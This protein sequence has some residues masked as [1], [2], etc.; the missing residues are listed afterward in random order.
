MLYADEQTLLDRALLEHF[1]D[2]QPRDDMHHLHI[3]D[4]VQCPKAIWYRRN[5]QPDQPISP[6][7]R[8]TMIRGLAIER[9]IREAI[10]K[11]RAAAGFAVHHATSDLGELVGSLELDFD[12][13]LSALLAHGTPWPDA[14]RGA[15]GHMDLFAVH[16]RDRRIEV[17]EIKSMPFLGPAP[18]T[19]HVVQASG[20]ELIARAAHPDFDVQAFVTEVSAVTGQYVI[21]PIEPRSH[22]VLVLDRLHERMWTTARGDDMPEAA[23]PEEQFAERGRKPHKVLVNLL[24][25]RY[26]GYRMCAD[27]HVGEVDELVD[28]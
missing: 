8:I 6:A 16:V 11:Q 21:H 9:E 28:A 15:I 4:F 13:N 17:H 19:T 25:E 26:C 12:G 20:Y 7:R 22:E 23:I 3:S 1:A 18:K 14:F 24:C 5:G 10:G 27:N 2:L